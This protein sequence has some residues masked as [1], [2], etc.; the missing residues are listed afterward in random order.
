MVKQ[1]WEFILHAELSF[2]YSG[3]MDISEQ[4]HKHGCTTGVEELLVFCLCGKVVHNSAV[5]RL[6]GNSF[7]DFRC[8][9]LCMNFEFG[10]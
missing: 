5:C 4:L 10:G 2:L 6:T 1:Y 7:E 8:F 9:I 3:Q